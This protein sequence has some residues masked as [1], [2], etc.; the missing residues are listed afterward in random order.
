M[1]TS[2]DLPDHGSPSIMSSFDMKSE[3]AICKAISRMKSSTCVLNSVPTKLFK[4]CFQRLPNN[5]KYGKLLSSFRQLSHSFKILMV[6]PL[7]KKANLVFSEL[8]HHRGVSN[9][10]FLGKLLEKTNYVFI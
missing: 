5:H 9:L 2:G 8:N 7:L 3:E 4:S 1:D 6:K 10:P